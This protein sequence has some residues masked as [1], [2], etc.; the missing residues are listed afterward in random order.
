MA[1][2]L[3]VDDDADI[4]FLVRRTAEATGALS[5]VGEASSGEEAVALWREL[6]PD[7][8]ALDQ[9]MPGPTGLEV[10][11][12]I[13][14]EDPGQIIVLFTAFRQETIEAEA[15]QAGI[16]ACVTKPDLSRLIVELLAHLEEDRKAQRAERTPEADLR[17]QPDRSSPKP[18]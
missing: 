3:I 8:I 7:A 9:R 15:A 18:P 2:L 10:A 6:R 16:R 17:E 1:S 11:A 12:R 13:L 14:A 5:V 4:R